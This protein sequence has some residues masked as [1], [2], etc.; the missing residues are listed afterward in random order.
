MNKKLHFLLFS[1]LLVIVLYLCKDC[2][3]SYTG[4]L[5]LEPFGNQ[6]I[7]H[8]DNANLDP[9]ETTFSVLTYDTDLGSGITKVSTCSENCD[10]SQG[11]K[12]RLPSPVEDVDEPSY[13]QFE[14][15]GG[16]GSGTVDIGGTDIREIMGRL[17]DMDEKIGLMNIRAN[18]VRSETDATEAGGATDATGT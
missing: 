6:V 17:D 7:I 3:Q 4:K 13:A 15:S 11:V 5:S 14:G 9:Q 2:I 16:S 10:T 12:R 18:I 8:P 1:F